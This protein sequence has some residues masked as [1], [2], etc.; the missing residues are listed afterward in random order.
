MAREFAPG[1]VELR[2]VDLAVELAYAVDLGVRSFPALAVNG[3]L[4]FPSIRRGR[5]FDDALRRTLARALTGR[6]GTRPDAR[7]ER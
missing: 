2:V 3:T 5:P 4:A 7:M 6:T 1:A